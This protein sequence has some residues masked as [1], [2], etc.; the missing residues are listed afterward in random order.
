MDN[1]RLSWGLFTPPAGQSIQCRVTQLPRSG[2]MSCDEVRGVLLQGAQ[3]PETAYL[4]SPSTDKPSHRQNSVSSHESERESTV[5]LCMLASTLN[6]KHYYLPQPDSIILSPQSLSICPTPAPCPQG[7][8]TH[9]L[10]SA[11]LAC[12]L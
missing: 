4:L 2:N 6:I 3:F 12:E 1:L 9:C 11:L 10:W 7:C 8:Q 5:V